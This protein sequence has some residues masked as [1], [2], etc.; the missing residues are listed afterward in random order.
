MVKILVCQTKFVGSN[1]TLSVYLNSITVGNIIKKDVV[2]FF[3]CFYCNLHA[4]LF[5]W[6]CSI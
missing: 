3:C 5:T 2:C 1:P 6:N 4:I